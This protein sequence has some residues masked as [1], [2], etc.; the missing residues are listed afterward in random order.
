MQ[1]GAHRRR[2]THKG[3]HTKRGL[4]PPQE[5]CYLR[6]H[7]KAVYTEGETH[8]RWCVATAGV[9]LF[10]GPQARRYTPKAVHTQGGTHKTR[11][12]ATAGVVL[13]KGPWAR[14]YTQKAEHTKGG[15]WPPQESCHLRG[16]RQG[17]THR[18]QCTHKA[19]HTEGG[20]HTEGRT[21]KRR[22][23]ATSRIMLFKG[24][25]AR[26]YTQKAVHTQGGTHRRRNT[27]KAHTEGSLWPPPESCYFR[28][29]RGLVP[30]S[31]EASRSWG[32]A[33]RW[34]LLLGY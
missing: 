6:G 4:W 3:G 21:H 16:H 22:S 14:R 8:K 9:M 15:L 18:R 10:K 32:C 7:G 29:V 33:S 19:V 2:C 17:G 31:S 23:V 26:R 30:T 24:P 5:S 20:A 27:Q 12:M 34:G 11:S 13:F 28:G 1:G 25:Q